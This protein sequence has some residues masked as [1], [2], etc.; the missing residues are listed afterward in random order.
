[1][2][3]NIPMIL[4]LE[5]EY[6][7]TIQTRNSSFDHMNSDYGVHEVVS[8]VSKLSIPLIDRGLEDIYI[9]EHEEAEAEAHANQEPDRPRENR[10]SL[11]LRT[12]N[13]LDE[14]DDYWGWGQRRHA[15]RNS[16]E[17]MRVDIAHAAPQE[18]QGALRQRMGFTGFVLE[19][20][21]R[22]YVDMG[23]PEMSTPETL[24]P[25]TL[26][27]AQLAGD[28]IVEECRKIAQVS[29][30][31]RANDPNLQIHIHR[32]NSDGRGNSYA[33]H[34]N[35][36]LSV[37]LFNQIINCVQVL[38]DKRSRQQYSVYQEGDICHAVAKF[39][40][41]RQI[42]TGSGKVGSE[43]YREISNTVPYQISQR[44]DFMMQI[45]GASTTKYRGIINTRN[46]PLSDFATMRRFHVICGDSNMSELSIYLKSGITAL[47]LQ[48]L[49]H[50][51]LQ[52]ASG[53]IMSP[54]LDP[55]RAY[56]AISRDLLL[57]EPIPLTDGQT[58]TAL[59]TQIRYCELAQAFVQDKQLDPVWHDIAFKWQAV[60]NGL[61][62]DRAKDK[63]TRSLDWVAKEQLLKNLQK[64]K[65]VEP[66]DPSCQ[67]LALA[68]HDNNPDRSIYHRLFNAGKM[69]S[70]VAP[71]DIERLRHEPPE[72]TRAWLRGE[73]IRR[74][75]THIVDIGWDYVF[76]KNGQFIEMNIPIVGN[77]A[78]FT[79][80]FADNP[81]FETFFER[82]TP[83]FSSIIRWKSPSGRDVR[84]RRR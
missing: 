28:Q 30:A 2:T 55:V 34:E 77:K 48:M 83:L 57:H 84:P 52:R 64:Q 7:I 63:W 60:L 44:A 33:G 50:G 39:F 49:E 67:A 23:H 31:N 78:Q 66:T 68:Y 69:I 72:D 13:M 15:N 73:I 74:Y 5:T 9:D 47:F 65:G 53:N 6:G 56:Q 10:L 81:T 27:A 82:I 16:R 75:P 76:F 18:R 61:A 54:L 42:I 46:Q 12:R 40:A 51:T 25:Y 43:I 20:G 29:L 32:N 4:G 38:Y 3:P 24:N 14:L 21:A 11:L 22:Y 62:N 26:V 1:M 71:E 41:T 19:N 35:Y 80:I 17:N 58:T 59:E 37:S 8:A 70:I 79:P 45:I 36:L